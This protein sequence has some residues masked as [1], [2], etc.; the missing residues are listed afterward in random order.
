MGSAY[1]LVNWL[2]SQLVDWFITQSAVTS[3]SQLTS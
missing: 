3:I 2:V 1:N